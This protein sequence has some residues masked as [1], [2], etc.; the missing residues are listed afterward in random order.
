MARVQPARPRP[1][2]ATQAGPVNGASGWDGLVGLV[3]K[4]ASG[5]TTADR[6]VK[7]AAAIKSDP[8]VAAVALLGAGAK[9]A[10]KGGVDRATFLMMAGMAFDDGDGTR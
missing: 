6:V 8:K 2:H 10:R 4:V 9:M 3:S 5:L 7:T 1:V